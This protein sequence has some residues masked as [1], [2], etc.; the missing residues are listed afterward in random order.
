MDSAALSAEF[1]Q[2]YSTGEELGRDIQEHLDAWPLPVQGELSHEVLVRIEELRDRAHLWFN[3]L[4]IHVLPLTT[5]ERPYTNLLLRRLSAA[6]KVF[7][8]LEEYHQ[9]G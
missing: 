6:I 1:Q 2:L 9:R 5:F 3:D 8:F 4:T 7:R